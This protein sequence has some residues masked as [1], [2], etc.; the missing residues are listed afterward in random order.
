MNRK[1]R[2]RL[3]KQSGSA[4][5][6]TKA[7]KLVAEG[8]TLAQA[9][10]NHEAI[11]RYEAALELEETN[12]NTHYVLGVLYGRL[13]QSDKAITYYQRAVEI[14]PGFADAHYN[15]GNALAKTNQ[16]RSAIDAYRNAVEADPKMSKAWNNL[17]NLHKAMDNFVNAQAAY[18]EALKVTPDNGDALFNL[19]ELA[20]SDGDLETAVR[21]FEQVLVLAPDHAATLNNLGTTCRD[22]KRYDEAITHLQKAINLAP[23]SELAY[24]NLANTLADL[25]QFEEAAECYQQA[26]KRKPDNPNALTN[27]GNLLQEMGRFDEAGRHFEAAVFEDSEFAEAHY[28]LGLFELLHGNYASGWTNFDWR[29]QMPEFQKMA[30]HVDVP[31]WSGQPLKD[32]RLLIWD[33]QG[34]GDT[35]LFASLLVDLQA[36][37]CRVHLY[38]DPRLIPLINRSFPTISCTPKPPGTTVQVD[39][40]DFDFHSPIGNLAKY[41]RPDTAAFELTNA[42]LLA[43]PSVIDTLRVHYNP[44]PNELLVGIAWHSKGPDS[45]PK[46]SIQLRELQPILEVPGCQFVDLQYG[47]TEAERRVVKELNGVEI[48]HDVGVDQMHDLDRFAAQISAL[49]LVITISNTTAHMAGALGVPTWL[50]AGQVPIW[51]WILEGRETPWYPSI[52]IYRQSMRSDWNNVIAEIATDLKTRTECS[53]S[54]F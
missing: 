44:Q 45:G 3:A 22:L 48:I 32:K 17:G 47:D 34:V 30:L 24:V 20:R 31:H 14:E 4:A 5:A 53:A 52:H 29:W 25:G 6:S 43:D 35:V 12:T 19:G 16:L 38:C 28:N 36:M 7:S 54:D 51:Y 33:E 1:E 23:Q 2:R 40:I 41:L 26:M 9:N 27:F 50:M 37:Q 39:H 11:Q 13:N 18:I 46:K 8:L 15:L 42:Y 10:Q 49:D 21:L